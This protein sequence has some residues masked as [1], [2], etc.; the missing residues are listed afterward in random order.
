[1]GDNNFVQGTAVTDVD[2]IGNPI[3]PIVTAWLAKIE[4]AAKVKWQEFGQYAAEATKFFDGP[5]NWMWNTTYSEGTGGYL[6]KD[7]DAVMPMFRMTV[8]RVFE[9][10]ALY[11]PALYHRNPQIEVTPVRFPDIPPEALG[12]NPNDPSQVQAYQQMIAPDAAARGMRDALAKVKQHYVNWVQR[13]TDKQTHARMAITEAIIKGMGL[14]QT[15]M[16]SPP[17]SQI[18]MPRSRFISVDDL[19][20]DP[21]AMYWDEVQWI[22]IRHIAPT[23]V[24][25]ERFN[26]KDGRL[27]KYGNLKS[28]GTQAELKGQGNRNKRRNQSVS[29]TTFDLIEYWEVYSRNGFGDRLKISKVQDEQLKIK[30]DFRSFGPNTRIVVA[31]GVPFPLNLPSEVLLQEDDQKVFQ[32]VQWPIPFWMDDKW[33]V[34]PL[35]FYSKPRSVW[36]ISIIKPAIGELRFINWCMSFLADKVAAASTTYVV[37]AKEAAN[38][39]KRQL[40]TG[41]TPYKLIEISQMTGRS[42]KD[43]VNFLDAPNFNADIW[44]MVAEVMQLIDKRTGLTDLLYGLTNKQIRSATEAEVR[45]DRT[46]IRPDDMAESV[47]RWMATVAQKEMATMCWLAK[48]EDIEPV[49]GKLATRIVMQYLDSTPFDYVV[50]DFSY[51]VAA[52]SA[53]KLNK[54]GKARA[55]NDLG[56]VIVPMLQSF[57]QMGVVDPWNAYVEAIGDALDVPV[58]KFVLDPEMFQQHVQQQQEAEQG[59]GEGGD[60]GMDEQMQAQLKQLDLQVKQIQAEMQKQK[61]Q[62]DIQLKRMELDG[63]SE[64]LRAKKQVLQT[65]LSLLKKRARVMGGAN[66]S[67]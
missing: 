41:K 8:N 20:V 47:E 65:Q 37:A 5:H 55:L 14:L 62:L 60:S 52:G 45:D 49:V 3:K 1:M 31:K 44:K 50:R 24:V 32:R 36:P 4:L 15:E 58:D 12:I 64:D 56:Q 23:N 54:A 61:D 26:L 22:A 48:P 43:L 9:A 18:S 59:G 29:G 67:N 63:R 51:I 27:K 30:L 13:E 46:N 21:D 57:A 39:I 66:G 33:P 38:E 28:A 53:R 11:G 19:V 16:I 2:A 25:E 6:S 34:T 35:W 7:N 42:V 17:G 10:V 40:T